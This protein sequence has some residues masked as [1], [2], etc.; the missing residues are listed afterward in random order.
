MLACWVSEYSPLSMTPVIKSCNPRR[1]RRLIRLFAL[2]D[3]GTKEGILEFVGYKVGFSWV[4]GVVT[5]PKMKSPS[6]VTVTVVQL[7]LLTAANDRR[8]K[9]ES[10][11]ICTY[12]TVP[13]TYVVGRHP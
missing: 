13:T 6:T 4:G 11:F 9:K 2:F 5:K 12:C 10:R 8:F 3:D 1:L 7:L